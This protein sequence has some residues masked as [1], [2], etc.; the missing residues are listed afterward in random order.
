MSFI[1]DK[2]VGMISSRLEKFKTIKPGLYNFRCPLCG[3]SKKQKSKARGYLYQKKSDLNYKC[4]NCGASSTFAYLLKGI[5]EPLY[6]EYVMERYKVGLTGKGTVVPNPTINRTVPKFTYSIFKDLPKISD[7]NISHPAREYLTQRKIPEQY[8]SK[9]YY[10]ED[11]NS[12]SKSTNSYK[13]SRI[14]LPLRT[15]DGKVFGYQGRSIDKNSNLRYI[16]TILDPE[17]PKIFGLDCVDNA[18]TVYVTEGPFDS[19]FIDNS[20]AM[21]G[22]D[23]NPISYGISDCV[24]IYDNEPRNVEIVSRIS[25]VIETGEKVVIWPF[26]IKEK[27]IND[28]I[29]SGHDVQ[30]IIQNNTFQGIKAQLKF[31]EWKKV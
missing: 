18:K 19:T 13:E 14:I 16:T 25:R 2:F 1:D 22:A 10:A 12:W 15:F 31:T 30:D 9:F 21:C 27:D 28:M 20:I 29:L 6:N 5:D 26:G 7:L 23:A 17:Y 4:H 3:D 8:Y 24:Y 11:F